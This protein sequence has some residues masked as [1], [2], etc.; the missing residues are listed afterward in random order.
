MSALTKTTYI[1]IYRENTV[2]DPWDSDYDTSGEVYTNVRASILE[3]NSI[4]SADGEIMPRDIT[5]AI[6]RVNKNID[7]RKGDTLLDVKTNKSWIVDEVALNG[8][9]VMKVDKRLALHR[10]N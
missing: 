5:Q 2:T 1:T 6:G 8:N 7:I 9:P 4:V 3:Q 10:T